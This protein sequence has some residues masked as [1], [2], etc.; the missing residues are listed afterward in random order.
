MNNNTYL[1]RP[2]RAVITK[3]N[4]NHNLSVVKE[5]VG[6]R[7]IMVVL[8]A[9]AYGHGIVESAKQLKE[10]D[11]IG[12]AYIEEAL[13]LRRNG[14]K[15]PILVLGAVNSNQIKDYILNDIEITGSS[16]EKITQIS[17]ISKKLKKKAKIHLKID[18]GMGRIGVQHDRVDR[19]FF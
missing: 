8:K 10:A 6:E 12:V 18:T 13:I 17:E 4:F 2:T 1:S 7:K 19:F 3:K 5:L 14:I 16:L 15:K 9:D 11:Y